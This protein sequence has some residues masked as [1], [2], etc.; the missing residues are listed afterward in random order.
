VEVGPA[1]TWGR[2]FKATIIARGLTSR[3]VARR[4]G[5][6]ETTVSAWA[7]GEKMP[8]HQSAV[9]VAELLDRPALADKSLAVRTK[10]CLICHRAFVDMGKY[11]KGKYCSD[12]CNKAANARRSR[13]VTRVREDLAKK[14]LRIYQDTVDAYCRECE[15][16]GVCRTPEC[17]I[18]E[19]GLSPL[20]VERARVA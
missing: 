19:A 20:R 7:R 12:R 18:Q 1:Q 5:Y 4:L 13:G 15:P 14:R 16:E 9:A 8:L 6:T 11:R 2:M 17:P 3:E 10:E